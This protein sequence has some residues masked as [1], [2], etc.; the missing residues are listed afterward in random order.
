[1]EPETSHHAM[2]KC[3]K[4]IALRQ[5]LKEHW[6][7]PSDDVFRY[8]GEDW[9]LVLLSR[10]DENM[11]AKILFMWWRIWHMRKNI[12]FDDGKCGIQQSALFLRSYHESLQASDRHDVQD[13]KGKQALIVKSESAKRKETNSVE[14]WQKLQPGWAK[15]NTDASFCLNNAT[16]AWGAVLRN[17]TGDVLLSAWGPLSHCVSA[18]EAEASAMLNGLKAIIPI[19]FGPLQV[20]SDSAILVN[21]LRDAAPSRSI[22]AGT[23]RDIKNILMSM[24]DALVLKINRDGNK[25]ADMLASLGCRESCECVLIGSAPSCLMELINFDCNQNLIS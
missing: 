18:T 21:E 17:S 12:I 22:I 3:T 9:V 15:I 16:G 2:I 8:T 1:M 25:V 11:R 14:V 7:L 23:V 24:P 4:A 13:L 20:E 19:Y 6:D 5:C 10:L